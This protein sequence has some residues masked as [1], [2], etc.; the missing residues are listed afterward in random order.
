[1]ALLKFTLAILLANA[2]H[3]SYAISSQQAPTEKLDKV[4][5]KTKFC[6]DSSDDDV[7][8]KTNNETEHV[9]ENSKIPKSITSNKPN[10]LNLSL[11]SSTV[12][13]AKSTSIIN[14]EPQIVRLP[15][16]K[17]NVVPEKKVLQ[18]NNNE[19]NR[20]NKSSVPS[21]RR[22]MEFV[23]DIV[24]PLKSEPRPSAI[25]SA[26]SN[27]DKDENSIISRFKD[28]NFDY[29]DNLEMKNKN[30]Q[31]NVCTNVIPLYK[32]EENKKKYLE[33]A[34]GCEQYVNKETINEEITTQSKEQNIATHKIPID[35]KPSVIVYS[36]D[37]K[38]VIDAF[39]QQKTVAKY[40]L[41]RSPYTIEYC[42]NVCV[43][44]SSNGYYQTP[45]YYGDYNQHNG[46]IDYS[47]KCKQNMNNF[48]VWRS[49][50]NMMVHYYPNA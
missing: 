44:Y 24:L 12:Q 40:P 32:C 48:R 6:E 26:I 25:K 31:D 1:M 50:N 29:H 15:A 23:D 20:N 9:S 17:I 10:Q 4:E 45:S 42:G 49:W 18:K 30:T 11:K 38:E 21:T 34:E 2:I 41:S 37:Y 28:D 47:N 46:Q 5:L 22:A 39:P 14:V 13:P 3:F 27:V 8:L 33:E 43:P 35:A 7:K 16:K 19:I 36:R